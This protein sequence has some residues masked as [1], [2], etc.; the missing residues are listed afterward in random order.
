M[1]AVPYNQRHG[2]HRKALCPGAPQGPPRYHNLCSRAVL[3]AGSG[4]QDANNDVTN[5]T[6]WA[7][8]CWTL[9]RLGVMTSSNL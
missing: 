6:H 3:W 9:T 7:L 4:L 2:G 5:H 8:I 1:K